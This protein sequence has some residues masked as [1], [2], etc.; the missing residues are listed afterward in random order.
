MHGALYQARLSHFGG[1][2]SNSFLRELKT[3]SMD[4]VG[5]RDEITE[6]CCIYLSPRYCKVCIFW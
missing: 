6:K 2:D 1:L 3:N 4:C 5:R